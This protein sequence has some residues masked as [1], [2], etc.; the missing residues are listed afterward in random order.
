MIVAKNSV[1]EIDFDLSVANR[2][3]LIAG[4]TGTGK[5]VTLKVLAELFSNNGVPVFLADVK[6]DLS[7]FAKANTLTPKLEKR[8]E[9]M[10]L[11][12]FSF[13]SFPLMLWDL[14][15]KNGHPIH[16]TISDMGP[17]LLSQVLGLNE[18]QGQVLSIVFKIADDNGLLLLDTKD[19]KAMLNFVSENSAT[20]KSEYGN[21]SAA[22][23]G[24]ILRAL[25]VLEN[26]GA[27]SFFGE[28]ALDIDDFLQ[29]EGQ[30]GVINLL[31]ATTLINSPK[32]Y[33]SFLL[34]LLSEL[35]E[36][37]PEVGDVEKPKFVFFFDEAHLLFDNA[38]KSLLDKIEQV[39]RLIRSKGVGVYFIS[40]SPL[41]IPDDVLGQLGNKF[42]HALRAYTP[43]DQK[44]IK[45][46]AASFR[47][48]KG[49]DVEESLLALGVGEAMIST[50]DSNATPQFVQRAFIY[51]P[52]SAFSPL[53]EVEI[54]EHIKNS[55]IFGVYEQEID[56]E[57]A[58][59]ILSAKAMKQNQ[60]DSD[61][62][63]TYEKKE[64]SSEIGKVLGAFASSA[65]R[66]IGSQV[67]RQIVRGILGAI[68]GDT[69]PKRRR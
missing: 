44:S 43:K 46:I 25:I 20:L 10:G 22:S 15:G 52:Q 65:A 36:K 9:S 19:L 33:S 67:G 47:Q 32:L 6:G 13:D 41:D 55:V 37:L 60:I 64:E 63:D 50:L 24:A 51:P 8:L 27:D 14:Y 18:T 56:R 29:T 17:L 58:Y 11:E 1:N 5:T 61:I 42:V 38:P 16:T 53:E 21:I 66:A 4:A 68:L 23:V 49:D 69:S 26:E 39:V 31:N 7:G 45:A 34:W 2:H 35:F 57:S 62:A 30:K 54:K 48:E 59:E 3:G 28:P 40:Q 12:D